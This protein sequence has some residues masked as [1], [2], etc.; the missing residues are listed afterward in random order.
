MCCDPLETVKAGV[1]KVCAP[2]STICLVHVR[3]SEGL[4][5]EWFVMHA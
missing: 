4:S 2:L 1:S 5:G 3:L